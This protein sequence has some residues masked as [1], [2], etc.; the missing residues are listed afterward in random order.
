ML[1]SLKTT[2]NWNYHYLEALKLVLLLFWN[3]KIEIILNLKI[4]ASI[5]ET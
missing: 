2:I 3:F 4:E 5:V 1:Q